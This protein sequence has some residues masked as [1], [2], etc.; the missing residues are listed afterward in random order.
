MRWVY[1]QGAAFGKWKT[2]TKMEQYLI[3][4]DDVNVYGPTFQITKERS[5]Y[6]RGF[7]G[8]IN[9]LLSDKV[10]PTPTAIAEVT[11]REIQ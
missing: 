3:H 6:L 4:V 2:G 11:G 8:R 7:Y 1:L 10:D 9:L 5:D